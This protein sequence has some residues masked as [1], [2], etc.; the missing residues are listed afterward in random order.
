MKWSFKTEGRVRSSPAIAADGTIYVGSDDGHLYALTASGEQKWK[1]AI[2]GSDF[3]N[4][5]IYSSPSIGAD[6]TIYVGGDDSY[7]YAIHPDGTLK[8]DLKMGSP[9][10]VS[11]S[12]AIGADGTIYVATQG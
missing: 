11:P 7:L 4:P 3:G 2:H 5:G 9:V 12:P 8:W 10:F 6:G 1:F